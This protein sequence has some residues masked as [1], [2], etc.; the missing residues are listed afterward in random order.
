M[1]RL[2]YPILI[3]DIPPKTVFF[4]TTIARGFTSLSFF[5]MGSL[6][7]WTTKIQ[8]YDEPLRL[9]RIESTTYYCMCIFFNELLYVDSHC[10][11]EP[12]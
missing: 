4:S 1:E 2:I 5:S 3:Y 8:S 10:A 7:E 12:I 9:T 6:A 11:F